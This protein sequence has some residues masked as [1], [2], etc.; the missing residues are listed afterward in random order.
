MYT[1]CFS[2]QGIDHVR[3]FGPCKFIAAELLGRVSQRSFFFLD[4][5]CRNYYGFEGER[6]FFQL[7][8]EIPQPVYTDCLWLIAYIGDHQNGVGR[9]V[10]AE[11][12][13]YIGDCTVGGAFL[14]NVGADYRFAF[15]IGYYSFDSKL[16]LLYGCCI[17]VISG[18]N[19]VVSFHDIMDTCAFER[20]IQ[21]F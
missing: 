5:H 21:Y 4:T 7:Y 9:N 10:Q 6:F 1:G 14:Q 18:K 12:A 20:F 13:I 16:V 11:I 8:V 3:I 17:F 2:C 15:C 19:N